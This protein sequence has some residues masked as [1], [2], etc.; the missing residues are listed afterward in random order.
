MSP[1]INDD[2]LEIGSKF[3]LS[4]VDNSNRNAISIEAVPHPALSW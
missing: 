2:L 3:S 1:Q 4:L